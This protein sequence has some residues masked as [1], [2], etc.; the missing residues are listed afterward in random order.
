MAIPGLSE[1]VIR[2]HTTSRSFQR[3]EQ[4]YQNGSVIS[5]EQ[6]GNTLYAEVEGSEFEP[7]R[8]S[9]HFDQGGLL[10]ADCSC[11]YEGNGWCKHSVATLL[12][13]LYEPE[14]IERRPSL[15]ERL[16]QLTREQL[17]ALLQSL[18]AE[19]PALS[20]PIDRYITR[21]LHAS[22]EK[23]WAQIPARHTTINPKPIRRQVRKILMEAAG[24]WD[25]EPALDAIREVIEKACD[26]LEH[27]DD[28]NALVIMDAITGAYVQDWMNLDGSSGMSGDFFEELDEALAEAIL[29]AEQLTKDQRE[30]WEKK[31]DDWQDA[32]EKYGIDN[33]FAMSLTALDQDWDYPPLT[34]VLAG[35]VTDENPWKPDAPTFAVKLTRIRLKILE[36]QAHY[37]EYLYLAKAEGQLGHYLTMLV[38]MDRAEEAVEQG[39]KQLDSADDALALAKALREAGRLDPALRIAEGGLKLEGP[40]RGQLASWTSEFAE[41]MGQTELALQATIVAFGERPHL[42][43]YLKVQALAA[44]ERWPA[45]RHRLLGL[46]H[47]QDAFA[48]DAKVDIFLHEDLLDDAIAVVDEL[49]HFQRREIQRVMDAAM[50]YRPDWVIQNACQRAEAIMDKAQAKYYPEAI[51]WLEKTRTAYQVSGRLNEWEAYRAKLLLTHAR[52]YKLRTM[53]GNL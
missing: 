30:E 40:S 48:V 12:T 6:S 17:H 26:F 1:T 51:A 38:K 47:K 39:L 50:A 34:R 46:L 41:G 20:G 9:I 19:Q 10:D 53:L 11:P 36:R 44:K 5:L 23:A 32:A 33:A 18:V 45:L 13:C 37:Q 16:D 27:G 49:S 52:K 42:E 24:S 31:L 25:D 35:N 8:L 3:G 14:R 29:S 28:N 7:Y 22:S 2:G 21:R 43:D 4:Y 15:E